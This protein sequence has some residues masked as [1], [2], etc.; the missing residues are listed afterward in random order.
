MIGVQQLIG[1]DTNILL[2]AY[3]PEDHKFKR[4]AREFLAA[5]KPQAPGFIAQMV[6]FEFFFTLHRS[7]KVPRMHC[8]D[9]IHQLLRNPRLEFEDGESV[10][11]ALDAAYAGADF[12]DALIAQT[13]RLFGAERTVTFDKSAAEKLGWEL[14]GTG[15]R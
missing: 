10:E 15:G 1:I 9:L 14:L 4:P 7:Y 12:Q 5:L 3:S 13:H 6:L 11:Y 8:L 2:R